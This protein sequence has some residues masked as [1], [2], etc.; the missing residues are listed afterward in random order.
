[1]DGNVVTFE[2][3]GAFLLG[4]EVAAL[5]KPKSLDIVR[6]FL[7]MISDEFA[8]PLSQIVTEEKR[9]IDSEKRRAI[10]YRLFRVFGAGLN[11]TIDLTDETDRP[12]T[13]L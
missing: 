2:E 11:Q 12:C 10:L 4:M 9:V 3:A 7:R 13:A 6:S 1:V 8:R 5:A